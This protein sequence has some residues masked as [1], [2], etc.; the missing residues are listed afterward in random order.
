MFVFLQRLAHI[1]AERKRRVELQHK[2]EN[3]QKEVG[4][5]QMSKRSTLTQVRNQQKDQ[6]SCQVNGFRMNTGCVLL[7]ALEL[8]QE[9]R[10]TEDALKRTKRRLKRRRDE[11]VSMLVPSAGLNRNRVTTSLQE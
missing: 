7:Q 6:L 3:L 11:Y 9:L 1:M 5:T 4:Q 2:F 10:I 8:I